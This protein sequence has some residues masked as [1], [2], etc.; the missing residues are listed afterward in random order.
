MENLSLFFHSHNLPYNIVKEIF[1]YANYKNRNGKWMRQIEK[2]DIRREM[3]DNIPKMMFDKYFTRLNHHF[4]NHVY[5]KDSKYKF[6]VSS[7]CPNWK[8]IHYT[9]WYGIYY[10]VIRVKQ[11]YSSAYY[12][13]Q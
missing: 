11:P 2:T 13:R 7:W 6:V 4:T 1:E 8:E 5:T 9:H 12:C 3:I 10:L